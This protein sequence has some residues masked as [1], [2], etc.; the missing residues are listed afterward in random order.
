ME[1]SAG[2]ER[3]RPHNLT[4]AGGYLRPA[5]KHDFEDVLRILRYLHVRRYL[6]DGRLLSSGDVVSLLD[7]NADLRAQGLG[8]WIIGNE[9]TQT[10]GLAALEPGQVENTTRPATEKTCIAYVALEPQYLGRGLA[11]KALAALAL[12]GRKTLGL[13]K[14]CAAVDQPNHAA[15]Q[16]LRRAGFFRIGTVPG[17]LHERSLYDL[18]LANAVARTD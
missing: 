7:Q 12:Y 2:F 13:D 5:G 8:L 18:A 3:R 4:F 11:T 6:S 17:P 14:L 9:C 1:C 16:M 10:A 15:R